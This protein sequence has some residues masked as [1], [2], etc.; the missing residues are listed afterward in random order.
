VPSIRFRAALVGALAIFS[1]LAVPSASQ[2]G[3]PGTW[4]KLA[5]LDQGADTAGMLRTSDGTLHL[6]WLAKRASNSTQSIGTSTISLSGKLL[7]TGTAVSNW[8]TLEQDPQLV[9]DGTGMRLIF[10]GNTGSS[11]CFIDAAVY[12]AT[13]T[14]GSTWSPVVTGSLDSH[15]AGVGNLAATTE[16]N[17]ITPVATFAA[18]RLFHVDV[19]P[20]CPALTPDGTIAMTIGSAPSNPAIVTDSASGA[21]W[22][23]W[24]QGFVKQGYWVDQIL[25][26]QSAP[27]E[28][29]GSAATPSQNN[30]P[31]EPVAMTA[32]PGGGVFMAYCTASS[33]EQCAHI[34]LWKVGSST[35]KVVPGSHN[36]TRTR[37]ALAA[38]PQ[39]RLSV[40]WYD[41][42]KNVIHAVRTNPAANA[43]GAI[44]TIKVPAKTFGFNDIQ[45]EGSSGRLDV[46]IVDQL[47]TTSGFPIGLYHTQIL[48]GLSLSAKPGKFSHKKGKKVKFTVTDAG[49]PVSGAKVSCLG[50][51]GTTST[52]GTVK[53]AFHKGAA[54]GKHTCTASK[55]GY[56][57]GKTTIKVT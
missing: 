27:V 5:T 45:A 1:A 16:A 36:S 13:S 17:G 49:Q 39:G 34:D 43:F 8:A 50:K 25:P 52:A 23:A 46:V 20:N 51:K 9:R 28:A 41:S 18:G 4:T 29:P 26:S 37:V 11:G 14:N 44:R 15:T 42:T 6:V 55:A 47:S 7:A 53:L 30:Q 54:K 24:Y 2:A 38:G 31:L 35:V 32:R 48:A 22:V 3:G 21:V 12:T 10:E 33:S 57:S 19:N 56:N 40:V